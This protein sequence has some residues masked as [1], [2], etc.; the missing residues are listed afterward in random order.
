MRR[1]LGSGAS[2]AAVA[3][4]GAGAA[5]NP[6]RKGKG[7]GEESW[8]GRVLKGIGLEIERFLRL[9]ERRERAKAPAISWVFREAAAA[10]STAH[11]VRTRVLGF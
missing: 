8:K 5:E 6:R 9:A 1:R 2:E 3:G 4:A 7:R 10:N 11:R